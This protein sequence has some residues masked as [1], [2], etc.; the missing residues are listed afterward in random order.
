MRR[1]PL[2]PGLAVALS[3]VVGSSLVTETT[4]APPDH[5][6][7][8]LSVELGS[9]PDRMDDAGR[10]AALASLQPDPSGVP[11]SPPDLPATAVGKF[12]DA[13]DA[14]AW[15]LD[16][17]FERAIGDP[18]EPTLL[19][20]TVAPLPGGAILDAHGVPVLAMWISGGDTD[21]GL[22][23]IVWP[24]TTAALLPDGAAATAAELVPARAPVFATPAPRLPP[25][26][27]RIGI[28]HRDGYVFRLGTLDR[29]EGED[30]ARSCMRWAQVV[31]R[32]GD[33]F[34]AGYLP[35]FQLVDPRAWVRGRNAYP[36]AQAVYGGV[37]HGQADVLLLTHGPDGSR[38]HKRLQAPLIDGRLPAVSV[39]LAGSSVTVTVEG[40]APRRLPLDAS[41]DR[42]PRD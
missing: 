7:Y 25:A 3:L 14:V 33:R 31:T 21:M 29:C 13:R 1:A 15:V 32:V 11:P 37:D 38:H 10:I 17:A 22:R 6:T 8:W 41:L 4:A 27:E 34:V 12:T 18:E 2:G 40:Q 26:R 9:S 19:R 36:A 16:H 35:A 23:D 39:G 20:E 5:R 24:R 42:Y 28:A 30:D